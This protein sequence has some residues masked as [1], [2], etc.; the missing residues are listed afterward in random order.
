MDQKDEKETAP[1]NDAFQYRMGLN[2]NKAGME[3]LDKEKINKIIMDA[4]KGSRFYENELKKDQ[5]VKQR[6]E[7]MLQQ[8]ALLTSSQINKAQ[9]QVDRMALELERRRNLSHV[10]VHVDMDAFYAAV[11]MRDSPE[12]REKP[13]A[14]GSMS[15]LSTSNYLARRFGVRAA[16]PGFIA[17]RLCPNL[18]IV[19]TNFDK[20]R[21]VSKEVREIFAEYDPNFLPL[22]LDEAYLDITDHLEERLTWP[23]DRRRFVKASTLQKDDSPAVIAGLVTTTE[24]CEPEQTQ[25]TSPVLFEDSPSFLNEP[26]LPQS[27]P[28]PAEIE[29]PTENAIV[30]GTSAEEAVREMRFRIEQ[31]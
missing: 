20:Y 3:G 16:M 18:V 7:K 2:D 30:F 6:I 19:P 29:E 9:I 31:K 28:D 26:T 11:E 23:E 17:K 10:I 21:E 12:L 15:M 24:P 8:K 1:S 13:M 14:V 22:S 4:T 25:C 5:Q 27:L